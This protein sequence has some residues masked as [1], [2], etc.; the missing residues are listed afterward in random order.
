MGR[1]QQR[2]EEL[3]AHG[4]PMRKDYSELAY[5]ELIQSIAKNLLALTKL[6]TALVRTEVQDKIATE[7]LI[8]RR[9]IIGAG[10]IIVGCAMF[11]VAIIA[12]MATVIP[13]WLS[14][15][16]LGVLLTAS[17][18][19]TIFLVWNR[20]RNLAQVG[21]ELKERLLWGPK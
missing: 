9:L 3:S 15:L 1:L 7:I 13:P 2:T 10:L 5:G 19:I 16:V 17:G 12:A 4:K 8:T 20:H 11:L 18:A 21:S 14:A 6:E